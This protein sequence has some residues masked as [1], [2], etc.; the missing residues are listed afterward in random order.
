MTLDVWG[1]CAVCRRSYRLTAKGLVRVHAD[2]AK[3]GL[4]TCPGSGRG[5]LEVLS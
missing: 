3:R 5:P 2:A 4:N 1:R